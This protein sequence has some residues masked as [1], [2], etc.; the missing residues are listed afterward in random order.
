MQSILIFQNHEAWLLTPSPLDTCT[1]EMNLKSPFKTAFAVAV[2]KI[3][4]NRSIL[5]RIASHRIRKNKPV[6]HAVN[7]KKVQAGKSLGYGV[8]AIDAEFGTRDVFCGVGEEEGYGA[9]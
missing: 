1:N 9:H 2:R 7:V 3:N 8:A 4:R 6:D 5:H